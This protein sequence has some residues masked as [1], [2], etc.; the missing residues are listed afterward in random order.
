[1]PPAHQRL[2]AAKLARLDV[3]HRLVMQLEL[4]LR[5]RLAQLAFGRLLAGDDLEHF[6]AEQAEVVAAA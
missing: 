2:D 1:M 5:D 6:V 4:V 3:H